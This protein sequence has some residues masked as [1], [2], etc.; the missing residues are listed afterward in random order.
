MSLV[1]DGI[2]GRIN[3][4]KDGS[5]VVTLEL[6][7]MP[8]SNQRAELTGLLNQ[9]IKILLSKEGI[10][11]EAQKAVEELELKDQGKTQSQ[12]LRNV[13]YRIWEGKEEGEFDEFYKSFMQKIINGLKTKY[14]D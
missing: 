12:K 10:S 3:S 9:Y 4:R 11:S 8:D 7:E 14:L 5:W 13:I 6:Q 2:V 1:L